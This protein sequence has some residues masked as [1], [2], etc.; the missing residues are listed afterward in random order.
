MRKEVLLENPAGVVPQDLLFSGVEETHDPGV[1][2]C[3][4][5]LP[6]EHEDPYVGLVDELECLS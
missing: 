4:L 6:V 1:C 3:H 2:P 5:H